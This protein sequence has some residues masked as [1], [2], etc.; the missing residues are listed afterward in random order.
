MCKLY[1]VIK[2]L[3][4]KLYAIIFDLYDVIFGSWPTFSAHVPFYWLSKK[5]SIMRY[6][7]VSL[8]LISVGIL[9]ELS[10][11]ISLLPEYKINVCSNLCSFFF[12][13]ITVT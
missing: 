2:L 3:I 10:K 11:N 7:V 13:S 4:L 8:L 6:T 5:D 12:F 9:V 1:N